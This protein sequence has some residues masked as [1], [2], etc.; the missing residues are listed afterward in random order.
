MFSSL[1]DLEGGF[2][3]RAGSNIILTRLW[4]SDNWTLDDDWYQINND[5]WSQSI[6]I[7]PASHQQEL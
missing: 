7:W 6:R 2:Y 5:L 1:I 3:F 4:Y